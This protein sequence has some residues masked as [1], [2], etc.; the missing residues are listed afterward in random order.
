MGE[1]ECVVDGFIEY[2]VAC[3]LD[4]QVRE[5]VV[6]MKYE[7]SVDRRLGGAIQSRDGN[8]CWVAGC[9]KLRISIDVKNGVLAP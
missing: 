8:I 1:L 2:V 7:I 9:I 5:P 6:S 4:V 3:S